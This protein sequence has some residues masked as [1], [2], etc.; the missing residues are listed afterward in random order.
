[1]PDFEYSLMKEQWN[2]DKNSVDIVL[3]VIYSETKTEKEEIKIDPSISILMFKRCLLTILGGKMF[4]LE[5]CMEN[6]NQTL[7]DLLEKIRSAKFMMKE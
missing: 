1:M 3:N 7:N 4:F 6:I 2:K 5:Y